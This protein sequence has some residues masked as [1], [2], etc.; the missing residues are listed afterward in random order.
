MLKKLC[1]LRGSMMTVPDELAARIP[2]SYVHFTTFLVDALLFIS[3]CRAH[4]ALPK[5]AVAASALAA[6]AEAAPQHFILYTYNAEAATQPSLGTPPTV[7]VML[8][9]S[10]QA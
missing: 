2:L 7:A 9:L 1:E 4:L 5:E 6:A 3:L 8:L 10:R